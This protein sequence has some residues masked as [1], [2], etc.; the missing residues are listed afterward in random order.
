MACIELS[1][2]I[3]TAW[4][5]FAHGYTCVVITQTQTKNIFSSSEVSLLFSLSLFSPC[6][7]ACRILIP[8]TGIEPWPLVVKV[9]GPN[10]WI[11]RDFPP[12]HFFFSGNPLKVTTIWYLWLV[13]FFLRFFWNGSFLKS[14]YWICYNI[15]SV[16][17]FW[18]QDMW[19]LRSP[20]RDQTCTPCIGRWSL[21]HCIIREVPL[22]LFCFQWLAGSVS[23]RMDAPQWL[24]LHTSVSE[25]RFSPNLWSEGRSVWQTA[26]YLLTLRSRLLLFCHSWSRRGSVSRFSSCLYFMPSSF[27]GGTGPAFFLELGE[28]LVCQGG[29]PVRQC[30]LLNPCGTPSWGGWLEREKTGQ[31]NRRKSWGWGLDF[32]KA[33]AFRLHQV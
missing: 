31:R 14:L 27:Q 25:F 7:R 12:S 32:H 22:W 24:R 9:Q 17:V 18:P 3:L 20:A 13:F 29:D 11:T 2:Y 4:W 1:V 6:H 28:Q 21:N 8:W 19:D 23:H 16:L 30:P 33:V 10:H 15:A 26:L 5:I